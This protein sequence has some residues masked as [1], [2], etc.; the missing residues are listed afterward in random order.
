MSLA[1]SVNEL[2]WTSNR[3]DEQGTCKK[4]E[5]KLNIHWCYARVFTVTQLELRHQIHQRSFNWFLTNIADNRLQTFRIFYVDTVK[6]KL[7]RREILLVIF[8]CMVYMGI[9]FLETDKFHTFIRQLKNLR[10]WSKTY[11]SVQLKKF[12]TGNFFIHGY[13]NL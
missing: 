5:N 8:L 3:C 11:A 1:L 2:R 13:R 9:W 4:E 10:S 12:E 7:L 6:M